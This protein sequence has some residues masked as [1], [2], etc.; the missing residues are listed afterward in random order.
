MSKHASRVLDKLPWKVI[1]HNFITLSGLISV[2]YIIR[3]E[4]VCL[5]YMFIDKIIL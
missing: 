1:Q 4:A 3:Q 5:I 2:E